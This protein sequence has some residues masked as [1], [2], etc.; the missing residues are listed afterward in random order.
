VIWDGA[1]V[2]H[3]DEVKAFLTNG[4]AKKI[5]LEQFPAYAPK[6]NPDEGV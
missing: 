1:S 5:H 4:W 6:L 3:S 2:Y